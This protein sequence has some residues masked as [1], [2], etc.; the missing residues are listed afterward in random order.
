MKHLKE[1]YTIFGTNGAPKNTQEILKRIYKKK[2]EFRN[3]SLKNGAGLKFLSKRGIIEQDSGGRYHL[4]AKACAAVNEHH[5]LNLKPTYTDLLRRVDNDGSFR[6]QLSSKERKC[7][8]KWARTIQ[9]DHQSGYLECLKELNGEPLK[10]YLGK[11]IPSF[12]KV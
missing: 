9:P 4:T 1:P 3:R 2:G 6:S 8:R 12:H 10:I 5:G 7:F 11:L